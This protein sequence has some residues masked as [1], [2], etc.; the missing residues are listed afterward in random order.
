MNYFEIDLIRILIMYQWSYFK[1]LIIKYLFL[2]FVFNFILFN[3]YAI[4]IFEKVRIPYVEDDWASKEA[5]DEE[6]RMWSIINYVVLTILLLFT[7]F[8]FYI[9]IKQMQFH[10]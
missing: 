8:T 1:G 4:L 10:R 3:V 2:P 6:H 9:E 7:A 5:F